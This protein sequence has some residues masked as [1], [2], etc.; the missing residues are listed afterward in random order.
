[1]KVEN[2]PFELTVICPALTGGH[3]Y[4]VG[5]DDLFIKEYPMGEDRTTDG[6]MIES[7]LSLHIK[8]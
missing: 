2:I 7:F 6:I 1:M 8:N 4:P 5:Y 3:Q